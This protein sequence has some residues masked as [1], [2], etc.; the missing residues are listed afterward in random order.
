[1]LEREKALSAEYKPIEHNGL[2]YRGI[3]LTDDPDAQGRIAQTLGI[4]PTAQ[5]TTFWRRNLAGE[6]SETFIHSDILIGQFSAI[7]YLSLPEHCKG[8]TAF[9]RHKLYGWQVHPTGQEIAEKGLDDT[10]ELWDSVY[11]DGFIEKKW[12]MVDYVPMAF[13]R[14]VI[15][16]SPRFHSRYPKESFGADL[17]DGRLVKVFFYKPCEAN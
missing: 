13:N 17:N 3:A 2:K 5:W 9:W 8:G 4:S 7:L 6:Q 16:H 14:L 12:E 15:F 1:M 10:K 11:Q